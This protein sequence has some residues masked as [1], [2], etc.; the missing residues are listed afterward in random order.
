M[1]KTYLWSRNMNND[2]ERLNK[3]PRKREMKFLRSMI[4]KTRRYRI[5]NTKIKGILKMDKT[6][7]QIEGNE[8]R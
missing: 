4:R 3:K 2:R 1:H 6:Q 7:D 8:I 5:K